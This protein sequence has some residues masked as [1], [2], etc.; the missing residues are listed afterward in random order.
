M[1]STEFTGSRKTY[2][3]G[4]RE[5]MLKIYNFMAMGLAISGVTAYAFMNIPALTNLIF[6]VN[7]N[8]AVTGYS[9]LGMLITFAPVG[10][11]LYFFW[12]MGRINIQTAQMLFWA[13]ATLTG[14]SLSSL[15]FVYTGASIAKTF[16]VTASSFGAMS[17]YGYSTKRD[18]TSMGSFL[19]MG[20]IGI[21]IASLAN[22][23]MQSP[24]MEFAISI[25]GVFIFMGLTAYDTQRL[26]EVYY[27]VGG[28]ESGQKM[29]I[30]GAFTLYLD[31]INL[32]LY[33][34]RFMGVKRGE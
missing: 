8:G 15:G 32:F 1:F 22:L 23:F 2:D 7:A 31:F 24:A 12:G 30:V 29:A 34:I 26:K 27:S 5:Y 16:F 3:S 33:L 18:L 13:Y 25:I 9:G 28:G 19:V 6:A 4:L 14:A 21:I 20:L 10:I 17:I 11:A